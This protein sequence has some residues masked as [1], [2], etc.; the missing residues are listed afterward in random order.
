MEWVE[1]DYHDSYEGAPVDGSPWMD[2]PRGDSRVLRGGS[3]SFYGG[4][5]RSASRLR[6]RPG[7]RDH[8]V[9]FRLARGPVELRQAPGGRSPQ[10]R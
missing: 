6:D 9:G 5:C 7:I 10:N 4:L 3:W 8:S 2:E 1:D